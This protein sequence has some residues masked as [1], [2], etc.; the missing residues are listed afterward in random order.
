MFTDVCLRIDVL[1]NSDE[2]PFKFDVCTSHFSCSDN[3]QS[4]ICTLTL[5][6][7]TGTWSNFVWTGDLYVCTSTMGNSPTYLMYVNTD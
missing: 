1:H 5:V 6:R 7:K 2:K 4:H 3:K